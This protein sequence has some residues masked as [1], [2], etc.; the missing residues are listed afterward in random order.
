MR[1]RGRVPSGLALPSTLS[2]C[3]AE[4][5]WLPTSTTYLLRVQAEAWPLRGALT[6]H[7]IT[8][9]ELS[10]F[11]LLKLVC[12]A[13]HIWAK[14]RLLETQVNCFAKHPET[15]KT[16]VGLEF[17]SAKTDFP[18]FFFPLLL[19]GKWKWRDLS[20]VLTQAKAY[21]FLVGLNFFSSN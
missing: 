9:N 6:Q 19:S 12:A 11:W 21:S 8:A 13:E 15:A 5:C 3:T 14:D 17:F 16:K 4:Q 2:S 20:Q 18:T 1:M 10:D 7:Q